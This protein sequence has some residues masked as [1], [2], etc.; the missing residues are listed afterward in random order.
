MTTDGDAD[1][2]AAMGS[3]TGVYWH[4]DLDNRSVNGTPVDGGN[5]GN[6]SCSLSDHGPST[7]TRLD[8]RAH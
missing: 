6:D 4:L 8:D 2:S 1:R 7:A 5:R 3:Q